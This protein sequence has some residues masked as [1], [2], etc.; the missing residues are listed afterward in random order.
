MQME[1]GSDMITAN[2]NAFNVSHMG[3]KNPMEI[4]YR[5]CLFIQLPFVKHLQLYIL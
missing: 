5:I 2:K 4:I 3:S 1:S